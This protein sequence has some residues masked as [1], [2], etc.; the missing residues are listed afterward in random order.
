M[1][2]LFKDLVSRI[3]TNEVWEDENFT[4]ELVM[5][6]IEIRHK[7]GFE[8]CAA[9]C[10][11]PNGIFKLRRNEYTFNA[12]FEAY[13]EGKEIESI[14]SGYRYQIRGGIDCF[15]GIAA[16][17]WYQGTQFSVDEIREKWHINN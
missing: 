5:G 12:A 3:K 6:D 8:D 9:I 11:N 13:K 10:I 4:I 17:C 1:E 16:D 7:E 2:L 15:H 14:K